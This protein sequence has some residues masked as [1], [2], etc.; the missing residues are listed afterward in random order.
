MIK[1]LTMLCLLALLVAGCGPCHT[2]IIHPDF[3]PYVDLFRAYH[4]LHDGNQAYQITTDVTM[5]K[6]EQDDD[7]STITIGVCNYKP[8]NNYV[9]IDEEEWK[10]SPVMLREQLIFHEL[11]HCELDRDHNNTRW[12]DYVPVSVMNEHQ[13]YES[14]Y[15]KYRDS[16]IYELFNPGQWPINEEES[17]QSLHY[18][19]RTMTVFPTLKQ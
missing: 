17:W 11:G 4:V 16:Y 13:L 7:D 18:G 15:S 3:Q 12:R 14:V 6:I 8:G 1:A 2:A 9:V 19:L 10:D 5:G